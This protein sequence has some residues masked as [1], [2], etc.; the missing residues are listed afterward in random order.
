MQTRDGE[1]KC[2][3]VSSPRGSAG[4]EGHSREGDGK[5]GCLWGENQA[6]LLP[7]QDM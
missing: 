7:E 6:E 1:F 2:P 4:S 5:A 3:W